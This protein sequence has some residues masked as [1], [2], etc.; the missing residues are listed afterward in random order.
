MKTTLTPSQY[1]L[2]KKIMGMTPEGLMYTLERYLSKFYT[3]VKST[4]KY[5]YAIGD[6]PILLCAHVDTVFSTPPSFFLYDKEEGVIW[7]PQGCGHDDRAGVFMIMNIISQGYKPH[8]LFTNEEEVG[9]LGAEALVK[10]EECPF[11]DLKYIIQL[12]RRGVDDCV[13]YYGDNQT[14]IDYVED[15][16]F[17]EA[18]GSF[19]DIVVLC[20]AWGICGTNLSIGYFNEHTVTELLHLPTW[21][22]TMNKVIKMLKNP[23]KMK[24]IYTEAPTSQPFI[25]LN[26]Y[27]HGSTKCEKCN[28]EVSTEDI[29]PVKIGNKLKKNYCIDCMM[30]GVN[31]C[32][33]CNEPFATDDITASVCNDCKGENK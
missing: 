19:T 33:M 11:K 20:P 9:C 14:F 12:D 23:P 32:V 15:F 30:N 4:A 6:I 17:K 13:F 5:T 7:S 28:N 26:N 27:L 31:W 2:Y 21:F 22:N 25:S 29:Y 16:G 8:I 10:F 3:K 1:K 24:F 18:K